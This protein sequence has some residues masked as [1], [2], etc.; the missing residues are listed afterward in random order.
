V[1]PI[2]MQNLTRFQVIIAG[3][4]D[5]ANYPLLRRKCDVFFQHKRPSAILSGEA[6]GADSLGALYAGQNGIP[7][8]K[9]PADWKKYGRRAGMI[10]NQQMLADADALVAFWDGISRGTCNMI[11]IAREAGIPVRVVPY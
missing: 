7:V 8:L 9:Y 1:K 3:G 11:A 5:F 10:R 6:K 2:V 4:R